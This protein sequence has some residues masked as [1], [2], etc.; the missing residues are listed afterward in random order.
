M[1]K[2]GTLDHQKTFQLA[3]ALGIPECYAL[4]VLDAIWEWVSKYRHNGDVTGV[5]PS[6][7]ARAIHYPGDGDDLFRIL[8]DVRFIDKLPDGRLLIHDW[9]EHSENSVH[10]YLKDHGETFA[11][12]TLPYNR[13]KHRSPAGNTESQ[14]SHDSVVTESCLPLPLPLPL[15]LKPSRAKEREGPTKTGLPKSR[16]A[17]F[18]T[19]ISAY[20]KSKNPDDEMPWGP[21]EGKALRS[22]LS[23]SPNTTLDQFKKYLRHRYKSDVNHL[24]R[25]SIWIRNITS[26]AAGPLDRYGKPMNSA[27][28]I[29]PLDRMTFANMEASK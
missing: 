10:K 17:E 15:P 11:D 19:A 21:A 12:G 5:S 9:P 23:E 8:I 1:A 22:W 3:A 27:A 28:T 29:N 7:V 25:P 13:Y 14:P 18:K 20:W 6:F 16:H 2:R 4:G 24:E 26:F